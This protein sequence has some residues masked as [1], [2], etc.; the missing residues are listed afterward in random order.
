MYSPFCVFL[1][2]II[3]SFF[4]SQEG[5]MI[6]LPNF[7]ANEFRDSFK[8]QMNILYLCLQR[9]EISWKGYPEIILISFTFPF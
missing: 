9:Y 6:L 4:F 1:A 3:I 7:L 2:N 8:Q 5:K